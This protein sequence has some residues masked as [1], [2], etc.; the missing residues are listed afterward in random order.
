MFKS[1]LCLYFIFV[2]TY[3]C[4]SQSELLNKGDNGIFLIGN[5]ANS[6]FASGW[7][8]GLSFSYRGIIDFG[9]NY[10]SSWLNE[11]SEFLTLNWNTL[12]L[13]FNLIFF[14]DN[15][16]T[17]LFGMGLGFTYGYQSYNKKSYYYFNNE[18]TITNENFNGKVLLPSFNAYLNTNISEGFIL[19][20]FIS[21][22]YIVG[23][24]E[25]TTISV[26]DGD[27]VFGTGIN[28]AYKSSPSVLLFLSPTI[29]FVNDE[30][31][32]GA[33]LGISL[34]TNKM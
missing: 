4:Y 10:G 13:S 17:T 31:T 26:S 24:V 23:D 14:R 32:W 18:K 22:G 12:Q 7:N 6:D 20:Y 9:I 16:D 1:L 33:N 19:Q 28:L 27:L 30:L 21:L 34:M 2:I 3:N 11:Q 8:G 25:S 29:S 5:Y 15:T